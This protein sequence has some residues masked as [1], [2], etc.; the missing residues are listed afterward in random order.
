MSTMNAENYEFLTQTILPRF[1]FAQTF[2]NELLNQMKLGTE[3]IK[4]TAEGNMGKDMKDKMEY[5]LKLEYVPKDQRYYLNEIK[6]TLTKD[7]GQT[8]THAYQLFGQKGYDAGEIYKML[9]NKFIYR[10]VQREG[11]ELSRWSTIDPVRKD[12]EG[13]NI[14]RNYYDN[15]TKFSLV[16]ELGKLPLAYMPQSDK[17]QLIRDMQQGEAGLATVKHKDGSRE[18]VSLVARPDIGTIQVFNKEGKRLNL[19]EQTFQAVDNA[20]FVVK[21]NSQE[22]T[23]LSP[24]T[25]KLLE[26]AE[27]AGQGEAQGKTNKQ[28][29]A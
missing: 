15:T 6:A 24:T 29:R 21:G 5:T 4:L 9:D 18:R 16:V 22:D 10:D 2:D 3:I 19:G 17:E 11:R 7:D 20:K 27:N 1:G 12:D 25:Q 26:K 23:Q 14:M 28:T 13:N 8:R